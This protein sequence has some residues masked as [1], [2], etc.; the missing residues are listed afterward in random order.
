MVELSPYHAVPEIID[1][2]RILAHQEFG[3]FSDGRDHGVG[4]AFKHGFAPAGKALVG[5]NFKKDPA[6]GDFVKIE[7]CDFHRYGLKL[8]RALA[9]PPAVAH[10]KEKRKS[11]CRRELCHL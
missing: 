3:K 10:G 5:F 7:S 8:G 4:L 1:A 6:R 9:K 11:G 2:A